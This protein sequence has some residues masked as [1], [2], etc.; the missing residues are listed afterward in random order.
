[1]AAA[2][3]ACALLWRSRGARARRAL[4]PRALDPDGPR[5]RAALQPLDR[6]HRSG[7]LRRLAPRVRHHVDRAA[8]SLAASSSAD[9]PRALALALEV[10][11]GG[12]L[13]AR[14]VEAGLDGEGRAGEA[15]GRRRKER[16]GADR[17][18]LLG[19]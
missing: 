16:G 8:L 13:R 10:A 14:E 15:V 9:V 11:L 17:H 6:A 19:R 18:Q 12:E 2:L 3:R 4:G 7:P 5:D 1:R